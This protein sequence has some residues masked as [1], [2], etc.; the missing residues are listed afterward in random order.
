MHLRLKEI[1]TSYIEKDIKKFL[2]IKN[3]NAFIRLITLLSAS[4]GSL[5]NMSEISNTLPI[6]QVTLDNYFYYLEQTFL[7]DRLRPYFKNTRKEI[8]KS[9]KEYFNDLGIRNFAINNFNNLNI[10]ENKGFIFENFVYLIL[11]EKL[12]SDYKINFWRTKAGAEVD[13]IILKDL[14]P[15]PIE[16]KAKYFKKPSITQSMRSFINTYKPEIAFVINSNLNEEIKIDNSIVRFMDI[17]RFV[18]S[19]DVLL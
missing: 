7:I 13:F 14:R 11:K 17:K 5:I 10:R 2:E 1:F 16:S 9:P 12:G 18:E 15:I 4:I 8:I 6:H 3:E 19:T